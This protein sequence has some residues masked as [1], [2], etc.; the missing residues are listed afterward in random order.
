MKN[1]KCILPALLMLCLAFDAAAQAPRVRTSGST[2]QVA[3]EQSATATP[4]KKEKK[5]KKGKKKQQAIVPALE[6][7]S[8]HALKTNLVYD[9][10]ALLNLG[11]EGQISDKLTID[12]PVTWSFWDWSNTQGLRVLAAQPG[13]R[14]WTD[15]PG[16]GN[17]FG[18]N[19]ELA[20]ANGRKDQYRYQSVDRPMLG[21]S[22]TYGY[23][24]NLGRGWRTE[25]LFGLGY[26]NVKYNKYYNIDNGALIGTQSKDFWGLTRLGISLAYAL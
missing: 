4:V 7:E 15:K 2:Q 25:I 19:M 18:I 26:V 24:F 17:A 5:E 12:I 13:V 21:A 1:I 20:Y 10:V 22:L 8:Y 11:Y 16:N 23:N 6:N 3:T 9:A 14:Y